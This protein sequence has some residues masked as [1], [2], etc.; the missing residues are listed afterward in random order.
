MLRASGSLDAVDDNWRSLAPDRDRLIA[1][2]PDGA[3]PAP[4]LEALAAAAALSRPDVEI[5]YGDE[6]A[7]EDGGWRL[8]LKPAFN[9]A[10]LL[11]QDYIGC[12]LLIRASALHR[13]GGIRA[14]M[15]TGAIYDLVLRA[16]AIGMTIDAIREVIMAHEGQRPRPRT[17]DRIRALEAHLK[18]VQPESVVEPGLTPTSSLIIRSFDSPPDVTL[19]VPTRRALR[20]DGRSHVSVLLETLP[21]TQWPRDRLRVL[22]GDDVGGPPPEPPPDGI[23]VEWIYTP[24]PQGTP[25]NYGSKMNHLWRRAVTEHLVLLNDDIEVVDGAWLHALLSLS[26]SADVGGVGA[27]LLYPDGTIQ[28]AGMVGGVLGAF[29]HPWIGQEACTA[30]YGDWALLQRDWSAVTGAVFA[31]RRAALEAV[32]GFDEQFALEYND[33]DL[34]LRMQL[35][36]LRIVYAPNAQLIHHEKASRGASAQPGSQT[37][38]FLRRWRDVIADD[39]AYHPLLSR[40]GF[41]VRPTP[42]PRAW[43]Q[44]A[45]RPE[46]R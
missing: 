45:E 13:L 9:P 21:R 8:Y 2:L 1:V 18:A 35:V 4:G 16:H 19:L 11:A 27:R 6:A 24:R 36:G 15:G 33:I 31:T 37:A 5:F 28:H 23:A 12:A 26:A 43:Y 30:T 38:A 44:N 3:R 39:P 42:S 7:F 22:I 32:D 46:Q 34:C 41:T 20:S 10:L 40:D 17:H 25:F 14:H 29:A